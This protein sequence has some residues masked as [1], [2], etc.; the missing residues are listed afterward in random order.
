MAKCK[1]GTLALKMEELLQG[2]EQFIEKTR[3][4]LPGVQF[5][6]HE[7]IPLIGVPV[8]SKSSF[9]EQVK[10]HAIGMRFL[11]PSQELRTACC[12]RSFFGFYL[13]VTPFFYSALRVR[14]LCL[15][16]VVS[17]VQYD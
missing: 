6:F 9:D 17:D 2:M 7:R 1:Y 12:N 16:L 4:E 13:P 5:L 3:Q 11:S 10:A 8:T 14:A 15:L